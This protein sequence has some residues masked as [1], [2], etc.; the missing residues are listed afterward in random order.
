MKIANLPTKEQKRYWDRVRSL[1]CIICGRPAEI[2]HCE[3]G[4]G[5]KKDHNK[6]ISLCFWHH[7]GN[8]DGMAIHTGKKIFE[9]RF[10]TEKELMEKVENMLNNC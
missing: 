5:R 6:V 7:R 2:H 10:G 1:G 3:T 8:I 9:G 4:M